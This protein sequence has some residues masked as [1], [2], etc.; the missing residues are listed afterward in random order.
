MKAKTIVLDSTP[1]DMNLETAINMYKKSLET[2][3]DNFGRTFRKIIVLVDRDWCVNGQA[4]H[5]EDHDSAT[6]S[7]CAK[8]SLASTRKGYFVCNAGYGS[9]IKVVRT[10]ILKNENRLLPEDYKQ[11]YGF[12]KLQTHES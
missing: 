3:Q 4:I 9:S 11:K 1:E 8:I 5:W 6:R 7:Y 12:R 10:L 2:I